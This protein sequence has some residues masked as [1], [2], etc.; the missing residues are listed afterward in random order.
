MGAYTIT[1]TRVTTY[2][3]NSVVVD[4]FPFDEDWRKIRSKHKNKLSS[5][6]VCNKKFNDMEMMSLLFMANSTN[7]MA[8]NECALKIKNELEDM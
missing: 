6:F 7:K 8:C 4:W 2:E 5:C 3:V 1:K